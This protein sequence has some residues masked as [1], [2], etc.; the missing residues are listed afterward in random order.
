MCTKNTYILKLLIIEALRSY[1][2]FQV[3]M[4]ERV[5]RSEIKVVRKVVKQLPVQMF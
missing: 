3:D 4:Q 5:A 2:V 1:L